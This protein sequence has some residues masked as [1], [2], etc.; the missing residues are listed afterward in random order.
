VSGRWLGAALLALAACPK[1][2]PPEVPREVPADVPKPR[3]DGKVAGPHYVVDA[4]P[5]PALPGEVPGPGVLAPYVSA[6][7]RV[8]DE[9]LAACTSAPSG[10]DALVRV[11]LDAGGN[12]V[13][14]VLSRSSGD[15]AWDACLGSALVAPLPPPP[16]AIQ[17][18]GRY[19]VDLVFR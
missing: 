2:P 16:P 4:T 17:T 18:D 5:P 6:V 15:P 12:V 9:R 3:E 13:E 14:Q 1:P 19:A 11:T 8:V 10:G 7:R